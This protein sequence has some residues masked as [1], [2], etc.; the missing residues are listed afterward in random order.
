[1]CKDRIYDIRFMV[2]VEILFII[3][4][5]YYLFPIN[6][7]LFILILIGCRLDDG[8]KFMQKVWN[9]R[10]LC[11]HHSECLFYR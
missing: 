11:F 4:N 7:F 3:K 5:K 2:E 8:L 10:S 9:I 1:M 6:T